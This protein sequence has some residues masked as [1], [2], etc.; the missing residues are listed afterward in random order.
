MIYD[1][2][3]RTAPCTP[4]VCRLAA[5]LLFTCACRRR[6]SRGPCLLLHAH[7]FATWSLNTDGPCIV[8]VAHVA[9]P[10]S[11]SLYGTNSPTSS[12]PAPSAS[13]PLTSHALYW[14]VRRCA[15]ALLAVVSVECKNVGARWCI[16]VMRCACPRL[17]CLAL[18]P[19]G[20]RAVHDAVQPQRLVTS[21]WRRTLFDTWRGAP[22]ASSFECV[23]I[24]IHHWPGQ[25][26][27]TRDASWPT[28]GPRLEYSNTLPY[29]R[30][31]VCNRRQQKCHATPEVAGHSLCCPHQVELYHLR[32]C[33]GVHQHLLQ[34]WPPW[35]RL[36][37]PSGRRRCRCWYKC[38]APT[39]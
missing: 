11:L 24:G 9:S 14:L 17:P 3:R 5:R 27:G 20:C 35:R 2:Q 36:V 4:P 1:T 33:F 7:L 26:L 29:R 8:I 23:P 25:Q 22:L 12:R 18:P 37:A 6:S 10:L 21:H 16:C 13:P 19:G 30:L 38:W 15:H 34:S 39:R 32:R 28:R 31:P